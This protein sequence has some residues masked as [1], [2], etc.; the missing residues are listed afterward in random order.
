LETLR[1][2]TRGWWADLLARDPAELTEGDK[3]ATADAEGLRHFLEVDVLPW[4]EARKKE[5]A[6]R[7]LIREQALASRSTQI[8]WSGSAATRSISIASSNGRWRCCCA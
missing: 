2:D 6:H 1:E 4:F 8:S 5:L 7:S 3:P